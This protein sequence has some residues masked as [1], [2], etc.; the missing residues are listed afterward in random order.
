MSSTDSAFKAV[1]SSKNE[2]ERFSD[3]P[4][5]APTKLPEPSI[6]CPAKNVLSDEPSDYYMS[7]VS[8][9]VIE[10]EYRHRVE[11]LRSVFYI[12]QNQAYIEDFKCA[13]EVKPGQIVIG[14]VYIFTD[15]VCF[16]ESGLGRRGDRR[17]WKWHF[18]QIDT[19]SPMKVG[20]IW[21]T[22]ICITLREETL[23]VVLRDFASRDAA[24]DRM[25][26]L[27]KLGKGRRRSTVSVEDVSIALEAP[28]YEENPRT[29]SV[30]VPKK[31]ERP[32]WVAHSEDIIEMKRTSS[33]SKLDLE[34][35]L[36]Q[37][38]MIRIVG[39]ELI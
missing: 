12:G 23:K 24:L 14:K 36:K 34:D 18:S 10:A 15:F 1:S 9:E 17:T 37:L 19:I 31:K 25:V 39:E 38:P 30:K 6:S 29:A 21:G 27:Q 3:V 8:E 26:S 2:A 28:A 4:L 33:Q 5:G 13:Y 16:K 22:A 32:D 35:S 11:K 7:L 20:W